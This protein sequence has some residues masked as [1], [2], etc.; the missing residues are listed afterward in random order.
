MA[1][2]VIGPYSG[3]GTPHE[4]LIALGI[5]AVW[6]AYGGFHFLI[7]GRRAGKTALLQSKVE[8]SAS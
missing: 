7:V 5:A 3:Y 1:F 4:P 6:A 2:Y 8:P